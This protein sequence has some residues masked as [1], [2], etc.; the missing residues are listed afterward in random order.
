M[1]LLY[2]YIYTYTHTHTHTN[3]DPRTGLAPYQYIGTAFLALAR[4]DFHGTKVNPQTCR[5][6]TPQISGLMRQNLSLTSRL[7][8]TSSCHSLCHNYSVNIQMNISYYVQFEYRGNC[9]QE[10]YW[11]MTG[12]WHLLIYSRSVIISEM[13]NSVSR[14]KDT[15]HMACIEGQFFGG[16]TCYH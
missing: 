11:Q 12:F 4:N 1:I 15:G 2:I 13:G 7:I 14:K 5:T 6:L 16:R 9:K 10:V 3:T 8:N